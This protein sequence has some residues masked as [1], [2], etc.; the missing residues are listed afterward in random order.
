MVSKLIKLI[1]LGQN[2]ENLSYF[3]S[4]KQRDHRLKVN[5][6]GYSHR[7]LA[8]MALQSRKEGVKASSLLSFLR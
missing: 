2:K 4:I 5:W 3:E 7:D 1:V 6:P 8:A